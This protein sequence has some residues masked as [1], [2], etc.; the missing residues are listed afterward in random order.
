MAKGELKNVINRNQ[1]HLASSEPS[2]PRTASPGFPNTPVTQDSAV[3]SFLMILVD[4][5]TKSI[6]VRVL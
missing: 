5:Y 2:T 4:D 3:N 1:D 6:I